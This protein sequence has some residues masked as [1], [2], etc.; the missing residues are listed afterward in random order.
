MS[1]NR[2]IQANRANSQHSTG[3]RTAAGKQRSSFNAL[4]HGLTAQSAVLPGE[5]P[6][7]YQLHCRQFADEYQPATPTESH[8]VQQLADTSWRLNRIPTL[9]ATLIAGT[10]NPESLIPALAALGLHNARLARHFEKTLD[11]LRAIQSERRDR[12]RRELREAAALFSLHK[13]K[14]IPWDPAAHGF[15]F[16][17]DQVERHAQQLMRQNEAFHAAYVFFDLPPKLR[18]A[19]HA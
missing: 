2:Q 9:E 1:T 12:E 11:Q 8:L 5:D 7:Q 13:H 19:A 6:A 18:E 17:K 16:S 15:V 3:P 14:G 10:P 4:R